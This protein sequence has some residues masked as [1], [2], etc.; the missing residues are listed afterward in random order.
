MTRSTTVNSFRIS[1]SAL[2]TGTPF[3]FEPPYQTPLAGN[4]SLPN[5]GVTVMNQWQSWNALEGGW[6]NNNGDFNAGVSEPGAPGVNSIAA[7]LALSGN[8][9]VTISGINLR[10]GYASATDNFNGYVDA[11]TIGTSAEKTTF[12]F[13]AVPVPEP[14]TMIAG[15]LLLLP[16]GAGVLRVL[17]RRQRT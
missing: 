5:Q 8:S 2:A 6:W 11:F 12:D 3:F 1:K 16:F 14:T 7:Y 13:E 4:P 9:D 17:R 10:V 15:A